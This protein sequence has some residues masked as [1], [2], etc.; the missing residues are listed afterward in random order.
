MGP[1]LLQQAYVGSINVSGANQILYRTLFPIRVHHIGF[2]VSTVIASAAIV[3]TGTIL[4]AN[5][6]TDV[7]PSG[8]SPAALGTLTAT[9]SSMAVN[10]GVWLDVAAVKGDRIIY[11]G[12]AAS[13]SCTTTG[14]GVVQ[15]LMTFETLGMVN[16]RQRPES[17]PGGTSQPTALSVMT[18]VV[19]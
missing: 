19:A 3:I 1:Q 13:F 9:S 14:T 8:A 18:K 5:G 11:P 15:V 6:S 7:S 16:V 4:R 17:H 12:E 10:T 2:V